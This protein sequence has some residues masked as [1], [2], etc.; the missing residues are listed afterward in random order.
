MSSPQLSVILVSFGS[1]A[2]LGRAVAS[3]PAAAQVVVVEQDAGG[4]AETVARAERPDAVVIRSGA[5]RGFGAGCNLGAANATGE[6]LIFLNPDAE[7]EVGAAEAL[8]ARARAGAMVGP[9]IRD[10]AGVRETRAR[11]ASGPIRNAVHIVWP[12]RLIPRAVAQDIR[13]SDPRYRDGGEVPYV[14]GACMAVT[15]AAFFGAGGFDEAYFLYGEEEHLAAELRARGVPTVLHPEAAIRH[16]GQTSTAAFSAF[17]TRQYYRSL[18]LT[19]RR[20]GGATRA[21]AGA[22]TLGAAVLL[23]TF[24]LP[25]RQAI[26]YRPDETLAWS[27]AA[28]GG[29]RDGLRERPVQPPQRDTADD[30]WSPAPAASPGP[31]AAEEAA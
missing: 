26:G 24:T 28:L 1:E 11:N 6:V 3:V 13:P 19:Y 2:T 14:Q 4:H 9:T 16:V 30:A 10:G 25:L 15:R 18:L 12:E 17:A 5:N 20:Q 23:L 29:I 22:L 8:S 31:T 27:R 21:I 7:F